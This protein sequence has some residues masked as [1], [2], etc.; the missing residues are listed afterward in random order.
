MDCDEPHL[1]P[2]EKRSSSNGQ[3]DQLVQWW[4]LIHFSPQK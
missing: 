3:N 2:N 4:L 1:M